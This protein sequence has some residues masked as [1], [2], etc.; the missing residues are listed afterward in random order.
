MELGSLPYP[1]SP[2]PGAKLSFSADNKEVIKEDFSGATWHA[3]KTMQ[4]TEP[5]KA[6]SFHKLTRGTSPRWGR[7][8]PEGHYIKYSI[9]PKPLFSVAT[10]N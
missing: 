6:G 2:A 8:C 7:R 9:P 3:H 10:G 1:S 5:V 4:T